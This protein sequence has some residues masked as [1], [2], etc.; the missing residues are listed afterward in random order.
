MCA[1]MKF[2]HSK[3]GIHEYTY[4]YL[5]SHF[6][7]NSG[8][9]VTFITSTFLFILLIFNTSQTFPHYFKHFGHLFFSFLVFLSIFIS[10][11]AVSDVFRQLSHMRLQKHE[12]RSFVRVTVGD[13]RQKVTYSPHTSGFMGTNEKLKNL[14]LLLVKLFV[15]TSCE[16]DSDSNEEYF[17][18]IEIGASNKVISP[19][20]ILSL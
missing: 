14:N 12:A 15:V 8:R 10:S 17:S 2:N 20:F 1:K 16:K 7:C 19:S 11:I 3:N 6:I 5:I 9:Y 13:K 18:D 4:I